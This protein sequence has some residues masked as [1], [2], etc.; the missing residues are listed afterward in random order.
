MSFLSSLS[1]H[2]RARYPCCGG[3]HCFKNLFW[4]CYRFGLFFVELFLRQLPLLDQLFI[5]IFSL[6]HFIKIIVKLVCIVNAQPIKKLRGDN[7]LVIS[8]YVLVEWNP[9]WVIR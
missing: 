1:V 6:T 4:F 2:L 7:F 8:F 5:K 3:W 9:S